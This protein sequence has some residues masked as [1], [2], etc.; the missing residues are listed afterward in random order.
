MA[1]EAARKALTAVLG[2]GAAAGILGLLL[3]NL[4]PKAEPGASTPP[5]ASAAGLEQ[6][7]AEGVAAPEFAF[8]TLDG[9]EA[10]LAGLRGKVVLLDFWATWCGPCRMSIPVVEGLHQKYG[11]RGLTV[12]GVSTED[13]ETVKPFAAQNG[14]SYTLAADPEGASAASAAYNVDA[15]PAL[16]VIDKKGVV[17]RFEVGFDPTPGGG[18]K[19]RLDALVAQLLAEKG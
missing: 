8:K 7:L 19:E 18:T 6:G 16:A 10:S 12:I 15:I 5:A 9:G 11:A 2:V 13:G 4:T 14:M 17:R 1:G 3:G